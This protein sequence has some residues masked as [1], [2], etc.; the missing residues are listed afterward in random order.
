MFGYRKADKQI[1]WLEINEWVDPIKINPYFVN[2]LITQLSIQFQ[3]LYDVH[4]TLE[5]LHKWPKL[6]LNVR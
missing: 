3:G 5:I 1:N 4:M 6:D 2:I